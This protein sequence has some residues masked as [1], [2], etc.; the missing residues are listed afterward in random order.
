METDTGEFSLKLIYNSFSSLYVLAL[1]WKNKRSHTQ[2]IPPWSLPYCRLDI[3]VTAPHSVCSVL[4][5]NV[6]PAS[7]FVLLLVLF[8]ML[9]YSFMRLL[10]TGRQIQGLLRVLIWWIIFF[11][12]EE[13]ISGS[14][15]KLPVTPNPSTLWLILHRGQ[16]SSSRSNLS[17]KPATIFKVQEVTTEKALH[18][19]V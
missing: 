11:Y 2:A 16:L 12:W 5:V 3:A 15:E 19:S 10:L 8:A 17:F 7:A 4:W 13:R 9:T 14:L 18:H 1:S 6:E